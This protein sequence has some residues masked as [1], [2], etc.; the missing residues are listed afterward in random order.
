MVARKLQSLSDVKIQNADGPEESLKDFS[1][2]FDDVARITIVFRDHQRR[3]LEFIK[4]YDFIVGAVAWFTDETIIK[5]MRGKYVSVVVQKEDF[6][7]PDHKGS[8]SSLQAAYASV[9]SKLTRYGIP[10]VANFMSFSS[11]PEIDSFRCVGNYNRTKSPAF[12]RMHN[13]FL[14][15]GFVEESSDEPHILNPD[16]VWTGSYN[17][18]YNAQLSL[19]NA[20]I[21]EDPRIAECYL[22][23]WSQILAVS[24]KLNWVADWVEPEFRIGS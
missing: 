19:E 20:V 11:S 13:K 5:A 24:E 17:I 23:E 12:P 3:L 10:G 8:T 21:I 15:G 22:E 16:A 4:K 2:S 1:S 9:E 7:K 18:S 14:I 6:L